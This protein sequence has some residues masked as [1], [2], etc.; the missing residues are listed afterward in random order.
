MKRRTRA[1]WEELIREQELSGLS[2]PQ[3]CKER[4]LSQGTFQWRKKKHKH[5]GSVFLFRN[6]ASNYVKLLVWDR[7]G[8]VLYAKR[9]ERGRFKIFLESEKQLISAQQLSLLLDGIPIG[10]KG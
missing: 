5:E 10:R 2:Q 3:F 6:K 9:L 8:F 1:E 7:T 4:G